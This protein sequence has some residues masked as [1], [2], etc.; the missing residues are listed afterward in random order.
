MRRRRP[1]ALVLL[2]LPLTSALSPRAGRVGVAPTDSVL[3]GPALVTSVKRIGGVFL[4][5]RR[6]ESSYG[7]RFVAGTGSAA[8]CREQKTK[9][10]QLSFLIPMPYEKIL[11]QRSS[12][13]VEIPGPPSAQGI[14][15]PG[16]PLPPSVSVAAQTVHL[17][18]F[19]PLLGV[20]GAPV[21]SAARETQGSG[22]RK[23]PSQIEEA[24]PQFE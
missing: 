2:A 22:D 1:F 5:F 13:G 21:F 10:L 18:N 23:R 17:K 20:A 9:Y 24:M 11:P 12:F 19:S 4:N 14:Q 3:S 15:I 7:G 8:H 16:L 6:H